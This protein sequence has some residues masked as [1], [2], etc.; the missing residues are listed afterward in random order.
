VAE[1]SQLR[2]KRFTLASGQEIPWH[3]HTDITDRF[4]CLEGTLCVE[5]RAPRQNHVMTPG[6][7]CEES[8]LRPFVTI[9]C[10]S[11]ALL[12]SEVSVPF[13]IADEAIA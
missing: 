6:G 3:Y 12:S 10:L 4:Y 2:A 8:L 1:T 9:P 11:I 13:L 5:T 7:E